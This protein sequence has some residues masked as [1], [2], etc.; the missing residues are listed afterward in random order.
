[1]TTPWTQGKETTALPKPHRDLKDTR[2]G[3][4]TCHGHDPSKLCRLGVSFRA[5]LGELTDC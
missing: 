2:G 4:I 3:F 1:M 5:L